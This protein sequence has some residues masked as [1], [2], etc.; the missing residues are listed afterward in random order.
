M[1]REEIKEEIDGI[2]N[3]MTHLQNSKFTVYD[4][5]NG[6]IQMDSY[7]PV[8]MTSL[9][10]L[11]SISLNKHINRISSYVPYVSRIPSISDM[12]PDSDVRNWIPPFRG[13]EI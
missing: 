10:T 2:K 8:P 5:Q 3:V 9:K 11:P 12:I 13:N 1:A 6:E 7:L 4:P